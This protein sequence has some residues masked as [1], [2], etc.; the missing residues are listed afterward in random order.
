MLKTSFGVVDY[1]L[2]GP[3]SYFPAT[4]VLNLG[5]N[6]APQF[7]FMEHLAITYGAFNNI[8]IDLWFM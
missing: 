8:I 7:I 2:N 5:C 4:I 1:C 3:Y 6:C